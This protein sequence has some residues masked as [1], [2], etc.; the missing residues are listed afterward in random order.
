M[1]KGLKKIKKKKK[2]RKEEKK[3]SN[4][5]DKIYQVFQMCHGHTFFFYFWF[6]VSPPKNKSIVALKLV[7][8]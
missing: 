7:K 4:F 2:C 3:L 6:C 1:L 8:H 5:L